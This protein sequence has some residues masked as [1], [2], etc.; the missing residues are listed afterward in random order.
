M[1]VNL[2]SILL[3]AL[4]ALSASGGSRSSG[5]CGGGKSEVLLVEILE[6]VFPFVRAID[7]QLWLKRAVCN[8]SKSPFSVASEDLSEADK[9]VGLLNEL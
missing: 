1:C 8:V 7:L 5:G 9:R 2:I 6:L 4:A 3:S